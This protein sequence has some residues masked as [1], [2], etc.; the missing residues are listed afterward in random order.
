M[1]IF[2][3]RLLIDR[4]Q[5]AA[6]QVNEIGR[7]HDEFAGNLDIQFFECLEIFEVLASDPLNR[8]VIDID[9][10][11]FD[12]VKQEIERPLENL[13]LDLVIGFHVRVRS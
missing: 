9:F 2:F 3:W 1:R 5:A 12:Q 7:H 8:N 6:F 11:L 10:V 4:Q 13:K